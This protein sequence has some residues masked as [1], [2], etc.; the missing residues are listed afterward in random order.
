MLLFA[1]HLLYDAVMKTATIPPI[2]VAPEFRTEVEGVL[3][4]GESLS[5]FVENAIRETVARRKNQ[6]EFVGRGI[7]AIEET[8]RT[9]TGISAEAV[10]AMLEAKLAAA[11]QAKAQRAR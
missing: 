2:R 7:A 8:Q 4:P 9:G 6:A 10:V 3:V 5:M 1:S 11:R